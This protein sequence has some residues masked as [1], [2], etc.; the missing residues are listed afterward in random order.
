MTL[1]LIIRLRPPRRPEQARDLPARQALPVR[2]A[3]PV[4]PEQAPVPSEVQS[5]MQG[6]RRQGR[7]VL[8]AEFPQAQP[9]VPAV[10]QALR[11]AVP[12]RH[13]K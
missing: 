1:S 11:Q 12:V 3:Q 9:A 6:R 2:Q 8:Q 13:G 4:L 10:R 7:K 5:P